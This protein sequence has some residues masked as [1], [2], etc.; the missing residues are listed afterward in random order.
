M[1][2]KVNLIPLQCFHYL[3][4][5]IPTPDK[6][7]HQ[8]QLLQSSFSSTLCFHAIPPVAPQQLFPGWLWES[9]GTHRRDSLWP[10]SLVL[11]HL[12]APIFFFHYTGPAWSYTNHCCCF[13]KPLNACSE[14][15]LCFQGSLLSTGFSQ[16]VSLRIHL[17]KITVWLLHS[18]YSDSSPVFSQSDTKYSKV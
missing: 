2:R 12:T 4:D 9:H 7:F 13:F 3:W 17:Q 14:G 1:A 10:C 18:N 16:V 11:L 15:N 8:L 5:I 6:I